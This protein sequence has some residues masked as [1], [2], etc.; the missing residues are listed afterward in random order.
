MQYDTQQIVKFTTRCFQI[1]L[2]GVL[3]WSKE[4]LYMQ[5]FIIRLLPSKETIKL[6][7]IELLLPNFDPIIFQRKDF[8]N[9]G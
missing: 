5:I 1:S 6:K 8:L 3:G 4:T 2:I 9:H 7:F